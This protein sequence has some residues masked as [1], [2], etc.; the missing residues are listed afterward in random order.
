M[1]K[2]PVTTNALKVGAPRFGDLAGGEQHLAVLLE[3]GK[4]RIPDEGA[5][6]VAALPGRDDLGLRNG[7]D[8]GVL[9]GN[10]LLLEARR[11]AGNGR[12]TRARRRASCPCRSA[13]DLISVRTTSASPSPETDGDVEG[14]D[15]DAVADGGREWARSDIADLDVAGR[16]RGEDVG[17]GIEAAELDVPA[18]LLGKIAIGDAER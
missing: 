16:D 4:G 1:A 14:L 10:A 3:F 7:D 8:L 6:D 18:G 12:W 9:L 17:A 15:I 2:S 13:G 5:I 11:E